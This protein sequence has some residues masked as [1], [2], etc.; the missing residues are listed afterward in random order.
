MENYIGTKVIKAAKMWESEFLKEY[1]P[2]HTLPTPA[3]DREGYHVVYPQPDESLY[4]SWSPRDVFEGA[5]RKISISEERF[6][7]RVI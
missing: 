2:G 6:I 4:H 7:L 3:A 5:Y 1:R